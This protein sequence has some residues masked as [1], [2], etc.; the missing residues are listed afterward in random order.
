MR[1]REM[2]AVLPSASVQLVQAGLFDR[3]ALREQLRRRESM[4]LLSTDISARLDAWSSTTLT[5]SV[6]M[7]AAVLIGKS[8]P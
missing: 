1:E 7:V 4:S 8:Q 5:A 6:E 2:L 3:R